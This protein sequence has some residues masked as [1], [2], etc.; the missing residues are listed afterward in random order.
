MR[1]A[2]FIEK[3]K[4]KWLRFEENFKNKKLVQ[5]DELANDYIELTNDLA[6]AQTFYPSSKIKDYLNEL[7]IYAHQAIYKDQKTSDKQF[8]H[9]FKFVVPKAVY[10]SRKQI[11][12]SFL[13]TL[14]ATA[15]GWISAHYDEGFVRLILGDFYVE[16]TIENIKNGNPAAIY[17]GGSATGSFLGITINNVR[18]AF[19]AFALGVFFSIGTGYIL[20]VNGIMLGAFHYIFYKFHVL[21]IAMSAIWIHGAFEIS[22][23]IIAGG[24][25][26]LVGNGFLFPQSY[27]RLESFKRQIKKAGTILIS[28]IPFFIVAGFLEGYI[29]RHYQFSLILSLL[30]IFT[31]FAII[32][33]YY[34]VYPYQLSKKFQWNP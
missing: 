34:I 1:E 32:V 30:I 15:I 11:L 14:L 21:G 22:V 33:L 20:F 27:T 13:I 19:M 5:P 8:L 2:F 10:E 18:V 4:E 25:G 23:I 29:T 3:N 26:I 31:C 9:F 17:Q 6:F 24:C 12:Y 7:A 16:E 28:T